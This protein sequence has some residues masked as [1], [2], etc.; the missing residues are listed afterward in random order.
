MNR[1]D[2]QSTSTPRANIALCLVTE[3]PDC[4]VSI[5]Y[6]EF[7]PSTFRAVVVNERRF[8]NGS[9]KECWQAAVRYME[10][11]ERVA[12]T[13]SVFDFETDVRRMN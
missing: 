3:R 2:E 9:I 6:E 13:S 4:I 1:T 7:K 5:D 10:E 12:Y 11:F 8:A